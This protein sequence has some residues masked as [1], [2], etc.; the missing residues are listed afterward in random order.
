MF[1]LHH[2][3]IRNYGQ[4]GG[5]IRKY[6]LFIFYVEMIKKTKPMRKVDLK[7]A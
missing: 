5:Q 4:A 1:G 2:F 6:Q 7:E 3:R